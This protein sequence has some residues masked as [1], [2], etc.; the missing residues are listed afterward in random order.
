MNGVAQTGHTGAYGSL[1]SASPVTFV[2]SGTNT[3]AYS[4]VTGASILCGGEVDSFSDRRAK[5]DILPLNPSECLE[6][7]M[8]LPSVSY[9]WDD[10]RSDLS[11]KLG[12]IAQDVGAAGIGNAVKTQRVLLTNGRELPDFHTLDKDQ[13]LA[14]LWGAVQGLAAEVRSRPV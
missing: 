9:T 7:V 10:G 1:S 14:V 6:K 4:L 8:A 11:T 12:F 5:A 2:G 3:V 13:L